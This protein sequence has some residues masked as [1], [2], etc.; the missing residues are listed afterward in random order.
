[1]EGRRSGVGRRNTTTTTRVATSTS[2]EATADAR[3]LRGRL[4]ARPLLLLL[5][6]HVRQQHHITSASVGQAT[7]AEPNNASTSMP[8]AYR[9]EIAD[10]VRGDD[11]PSR[12]ADVIKVG[13]VIEVV[14]AVESSQDLARAYRTS[15]TADD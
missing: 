15:P 6:L 7:A 12:S 10:P 5:L 4:L 3:L 14:V 11:A 13:V 2:A 9:V 1:M 8:P